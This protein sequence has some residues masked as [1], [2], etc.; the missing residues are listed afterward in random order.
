M[1]PKVHYIKCWPEFYKPVRKG[2]KTFEL[3]KNDRGYE[4]GDVL[5]I[6]EWDQ[7]GNGYTGNECV[8]VVSSIVKEGF[9]LEKGHCCMG[10]KKSIKRSLQY[11]IHKRNNDNE[12]LWEL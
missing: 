2:E 1:Q 6:Q 7:G 4:K 5:V 10:M 9:G 11:W 3:R 8:R 12:V